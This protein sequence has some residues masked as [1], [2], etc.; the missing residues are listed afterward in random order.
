MSG[1][2]LDST[3]LV[4]LSQDDEPEKTKCESFVGA[5][6]PAEV[7]YYAPRELLAGLVNYYCI[8][9]NRLLASQTVVEAV[10][11]LSN[12]PAV[13]GRRREVPASTLLQALNTAWPQGQALSPEDGRRECLQD[14]M[15]LATQLWDRACAPKLVKY[16]QHLACFN[17]GALSVNSTSREL[18]GPNDS[19]NCKKTERCAAAGYLHDDLVTLTNMIDALDPSKLDEKLKNKKEIQSRRAALKE[20]VKRTPKLFDKRRCRAFG[21]AYFAAKC[22]PGTVLATTNVEDFEPLCRKL[23]KPY[24]KP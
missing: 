15:I 16:V 11:A 12:M 19:F 9:H 21:D 13:A 22:P 23:G 6:Q 1:C 2:F 20:L 14:I 10:I 17:A 8:A 24:Q 3:V 7:P 18:R 5:N 4:H